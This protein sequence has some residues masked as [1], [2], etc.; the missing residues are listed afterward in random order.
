MEIIL[1]KKSVEKVFVVLLG[2]F[3]AAFLKVMGRTV[4]YKYIICTCNR[5]SIQ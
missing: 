4:M 1:S 5:D 2:M 3:R